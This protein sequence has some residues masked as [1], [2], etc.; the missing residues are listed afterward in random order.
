[1]VP[2]SVFLKF[3]NSR[4]SSILLVIFGDSAISMLAQFSFIYVRLLI[5]DP[6]ETNSSHISAVRIFEQMTLVRDQRPSGHGYVLCAFSELLSILK[7]REARDDMYH[8]RPA[9]R[10]RRS[11]F[12]RLLFVLLDI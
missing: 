10:E 8:A 1:M 4:H 9:L 6:S 7:I 3:H 11:P 2:S 12:I 5:Y